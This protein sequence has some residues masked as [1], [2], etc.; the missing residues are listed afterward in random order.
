MGD[1]PN[2][3]Y[4]TLSGLCGDLSGALTEYQRIVPSKEILESPTPASSCEITSRQKSSPS[5][6]VKVYAADPIVARDTAVRLYNETVAS[7][8]ESES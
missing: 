8:K 3:A 2:Y 1:M 5:V 7:F 4:E 6:A